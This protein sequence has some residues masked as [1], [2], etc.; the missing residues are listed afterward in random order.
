MDGDCFTTLQWQHRMYLFLQHL[1]TDMTLK[2]LRLPYVQ[3][4]QLKWQDDVYGTLIELVE[5]KI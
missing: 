1:Q 2:P 3:W 4:L 5:V